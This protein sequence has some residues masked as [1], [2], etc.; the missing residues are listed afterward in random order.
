[1]N[2]PALSKR[3]PTAVFI[4]AFSHLSLE[5]LHNFLPIVYPLLIEQMSLTYAQ[6]GTLALVI[7]LG[8]TLIQPLF[9]YWSDRWDARFIIVGSIVWSGL[10]MGLVGLMAY[11][12]GQYW[13]LIPVVALG[14]MGSA[15]FHPAGASLAAVGLQKRRGAALAIFSVGG[16]LGSALSPL[17]VSVGLLWWGIRG[18]AV[19]ILAGLLI[20]LFLYVQM[21]HVPKPHQDHTQKSTGEHGSWLALG[22][23]I[24]IVAARSWFQG[25]LI[26]YLPEWLQSQGR[27]LEAAGSIFSV[28][29]VSVSIGSLTGGTLSDRV[30]RIP[31]VVGSLLLLGPFHWLLL[32]TSGALQ[33]VF[34]SLVGIMIG[35][36]FPVGILMAQEVWPQA[37]GLASSLVLGLGWLPAGIGAWLVG[38]IA[39]K[40]SLTY[41]LTT[42]LFVPLVGVTAVILFKLRYGESTAQQT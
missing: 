32:H 28:L 7:S 29:L 35:A 27:P 42:L 15:A 22:L 30:G 14:G 4:I 36:T 24:L 19:T 3:L 16:N 33:I 6:I 11:Y 26:T 18:T 8:G 10:L 37:K 38:F 40:T 25:S 12:G 9:G 31:I 34:V 5:L 39:D 17:L 1:M 21:R 13:M 23:I 2:I 41:G 20:G